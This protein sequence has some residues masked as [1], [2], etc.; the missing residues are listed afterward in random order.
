MSM[1]DRRKAPG[2]VVVVQ[3]RTLG[4]GVPGSR[5]SRVAVSCGIEQSHIFAAPQ[6]VIRKISSQY[7]VT[8]MTVKGNRKL[9]VFNISFLK[10]MG[11]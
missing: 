1:A 11:S 5:L 6:V 2:A 9:F 4:R 3:H 10:V 7:Q 8:K